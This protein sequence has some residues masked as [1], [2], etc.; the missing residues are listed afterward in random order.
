MPTF[1]RAPRSQT[2][3][4]RRVRARVAIRWL[5][6]ASNKMWRKCSQNTFHNQNQLFLQFFDGPL[7]A[8]LLGKE[9]LH[10]HLQAQKGHERPDKL[11]DAVNQSQIHGPSAALHS[12]WLWEMLGPEPLNQSQTSQTSQRSIQ[13]GFSAKWSFASK[14][15][16][17]ISWTHLLMA[18]QQ[19]KRLHAMFKFK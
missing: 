9:L 15:E 13:F 4:T 16:S 14:F 7:L 18:L 10:F 2:R 8:G 11:L 12:A 6:K 17:N 5:E 1:N 3:P 19:C